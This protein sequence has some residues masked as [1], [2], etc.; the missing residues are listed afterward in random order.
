M[1]AKQMIDQLLD[2]NDEE[3][4]KMLLFYY[5]QGLEIGKEEASYEIATKLAS[6]NVDKSIISL[7]TRIN[8]LDL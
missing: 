8:T 6:Q 3:K 1:N 4:V 7:T 5:Q 2:L